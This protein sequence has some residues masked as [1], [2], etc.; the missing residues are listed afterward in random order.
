MGA[1]QNVIR[2]S[3]TSV[4]I[5]EVLSS[6]SEITRSEGTSFDSKRSIDLKTQFSDF[7]KNYLINTNAT[8]TT[9]AW[10]AP[11]SLLIPSQVFTVE[12]LKSYLK[13][14]FGEKENDL[15][16]DYNRL[17]ELDMVNVYSI[18]DWVKSAAILNIPTVIIQHD[19]SF[20]LRG[21]FQGATF[22]PQGYIVV[23]ESYFLFCIIKHN[24][25]I[26]IN[27]FDY[28]SEEDMLYY[29]SYTLQQLYLMQAQMEILLAA[30]FEEMEEIITAVIGLQ[31]QRNL[32]P[33]M[34][35]KFSQDLLTSLP[36]KCV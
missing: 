35:W 20:L 27:H 14:V 5:T 1:K 2:L 15:P 11:N 36:V 10:C 13:F 18:P 33:S 32:F 8:E 23:Y 21:L 24:Q 31:A 26:F 9:L 29:V 4:T 22:K 12:S 28:Q 7:L 16:A 25:L 17:S 34:T 3:E 19:V 6:S 30:G